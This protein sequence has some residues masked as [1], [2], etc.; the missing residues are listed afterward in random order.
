[1]VN[2]PG[3][4]KQREPLLRVTHLARA[5]APPA[6]VTGLYSQTTNQ[7]ITIST[8]VPHHLASRD[9]VFLTFTDTSGQPRPPR[10]LMWSRWWGRRSSR[11]PRRS[12]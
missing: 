3:Y 10:R 5:F 7:V 11:L 1:M 12:C 9:T 8:A 6:P 2:Q 4:G